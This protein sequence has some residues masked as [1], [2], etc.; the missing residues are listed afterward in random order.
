MP[1][2]IPDRNRISCIPARVQSKVTDNPACNSWEL[3]TSVYGPNQNT[4]RGTIPPG[5]TMEGFFLGE[6]VPGGR[7][8]TRACDPIAVNDAL[9]Q[10]SHATLLVHFGF[11]SLY[12]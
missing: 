4:S 12:R 6:S 1:H 8:E 9:Y 2:M 7:N 11:D 10:L 3:D 5:Q